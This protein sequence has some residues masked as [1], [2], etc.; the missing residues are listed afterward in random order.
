MHYAV[1]KTYTTVF[2]T[3]MSSSLY[4]RLKVTESLKT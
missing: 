1:Y 4:V 3:V 2:I